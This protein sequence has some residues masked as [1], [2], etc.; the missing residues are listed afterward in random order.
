MSGGGIVHKETHRI[1]HSRS[2]ANSIE[3]SAEAEVLLDP[4]ARV[5]VLSI[6]GFDEDRCMLR[7]SALTF[8]SLISIVPILAMVFGI[9]KGFGFDKVLEERVRQ[10]FQGQEEVI[11]HAMTF[12]QNLLKN[13][14]GGLVAGI[15]VAFLFWAI[16]KVL[17]NIEDSLNEIWGIKKPRGWIRKFSD[18]L[19][20]MLICPI[21]FI[22][23]S[24]MTVVVSSEVMDVLSSL[25]YLSFMAGPVRILL[26]L[27][28][29]AIL[30]GLFA[31]MYLFLP[32]GKVNP[33]SALL[34]GIL[35][36][37]IY[38]VVQWAYIN[39]QIGIASYNAI[40]G[41]FAA[42]PLF[43]VWLQLSWLLLLYGA[44]ISFAHQNAETYEYEQDCL[45]I[46]PAFKR[47]VTLA[48]AQDCIERFCREEPPSTAEEISH[49]LGSPIRLINEI[50]YDL[51][52]AGILSELAGDR[53]KT[54][55]YQP[56]IDVADLTIR[57]VLDRLDNRGIETVPLV[58]SEVVERISSSL[59]RFRQIEASAPENVNLR[60]L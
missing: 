10:Q 18:Y 40:Y 52:A 28:P 30:W 59:D 35:A 45:S 43:L 57:D 21:L 9:A 13:T 14:Q 15:G 31:F 17:G 19:S 7:A 22:V 49:R 53:E 12:A 6:R 32:N 36:G 16:I 44:E 27:L 47:L 42:L 46:R 8:Y 4:G 54:A 33:R 38:Q 25:P 11:A 39:F 51:T 2:L 34:G 37:T 26:R 5:I 29:F 20:F 1:S 50:L 3:R 55:A 41:S 56:A 58:K 60:D 24:S 48:V 23:A